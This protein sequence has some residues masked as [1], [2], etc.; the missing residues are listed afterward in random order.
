MQLIADANIARLTRWHQHCRQ[1]KRRRHCARFA[2]VVVGGL[3][4]HCEI[5]SHLGLATIELD[6]C[7]LGCMCRRHRRVDRRLSTRRRAL[8]RRAVQRRR[9]RRVAQRL[10]TCLATDWHRSCIANPH[11]TPQFE[12]AILGGTTGANC[13]TKQTKKKEVRSCNRVEPLLEQQMR[14]CL[15]VVGHDGET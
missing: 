10:L 14:S 9:R 8:G 13:K 2:V 11:H 12:V 6:R 1:L 4:R 7:N 3:C 5:G 15:P